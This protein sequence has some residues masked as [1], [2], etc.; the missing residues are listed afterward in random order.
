[1]RRNNAVFGC[2][3]GLLL[4]LVGAVIVY[5]ILFK[6]YSFEGYLNRLFSDGRIAGKVIALSILINILPFIF[7]TNR[8]LDLTGRGILVATM[9]YAV[10]F[11]LVKFVW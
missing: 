4:P 9:L 2:I 8:K 5:F 11:A 7:Y 3:I 10:L 1:M 6:G